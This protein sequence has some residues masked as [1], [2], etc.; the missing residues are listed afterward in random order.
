[1]RAA[2]D[3]VLVSCYEPGYQPIAVASTAAFLRAAGY[4]PLTID[5]AVEELA[6][7][8]LDRLARAR[9]VAISAPMHTAMT[10]GLR[11]ASQV[12][13]LN[14][15]A[16]LCFFGM[17]AALNRARLARAEPGADGRPLADS[18]LGVECEEDLVALAAALERGGHDGPVGAPV[19][20]GSPEP[21]RLR[22]LPF[23]VPERGD[24]PPLD[25]YA[26]LLVGDERRVAGHVEATRGCKYHC[27][28]C[29]IPP[30]YGGRFFAVPVE[31]VLE[32]ARRQV[33]AG[34]R[35]ITFGDPD[36]LNSAKHALAVARGLH[37]AHP[38]VTFSFTAKIEHIVTA[39]PE[40]SAFFAELAALGCVFVVSAVESLSD[41][42]LALLDKGHTGADVIRALAI[43]R[44]A[45]ISLRPTFVAFTPFTTLTDYLALCRFIRDHDL[46]QEVDPI[47]LAIRLLIPPGSL[48]LARPE[49]APFLIGLDEEALAHRWRH[50]DARMDQLASQVMALVEQSTQDRES[51]HATFARIHALAAGLAGEA[52]P[53]ISLKR[54]R[55]APPRLSEPWFCCA[56]PT[57]LQLGKTTGR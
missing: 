39:R 51:P 43:V 57:A 17:Y 44:G 18:V 8:G 47:Q 3:I 42:V 5:L 26:R 38:E 27:R 22:R 55:P 49:L 45:G 31:V 13:A 19:S 36:F 4:A 1:M 34:A 6:E 48:L 29:P 28:H 53:P 12:R 10:I 46:E 9:L 15:G 33:A 56:E 21:A 14:G 40:P 7:R 41:R 11:L 30:V 24:L 2:G 32:D 54:R 23:M 20:P 37:A 16:H 35:H 50:P 52:A 25:R